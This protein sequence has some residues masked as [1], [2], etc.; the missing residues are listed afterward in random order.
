MALQMVGQRLPSERD[1]AARLQIS[2]PSLRAILAQL[3][4]EGLVEARPKSGTYVVD[5]RPSRLHRIALLIDADLKLGDDPF[6]VSVVDTLQRSIQ[7][8]GARCV[9]ERTHGEGP[10]SVVEDGILTLGMAGHDLVAMQ[11]ADGPPLVGLFLDAGT[12]PNRRASIFQLEDREAGYDAAKHLLQRGVRDIVFLGR[13]DIPAS[14]ERL[15]G[16][17]AAAVEVGATF[18]LISCHLNYPDGLRLGR[19]IDLP[20]SDTPL[21]VVATNDWLALGFRTGLRDRHIPAERNVHIASFDGLAVTADPS[22]DI[23]SL[24]VPIQEIAADAVA[25]LQRLQRSPAATGRVIRYSLR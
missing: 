20:D 12:R 10:H 5:Q 7:A 21:G 6:I 15:S 23:T 22:L 13:R 1:L 24:A 18:R 3:Q 16:A 9:I 25:E 17:E 19:Q 2:R 4:K 8:V 14:Q 11:R